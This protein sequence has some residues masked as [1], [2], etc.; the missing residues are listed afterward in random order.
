LNLAAPFCRF[1]S[2]KPQQLRYKLSTAYAHRSGAVNLL[3]RLLSPSPGRLGFKSMSSSGLGSPSLQ[4]RNRPTALRPP[5]PLGL[6]PVAVAPHVAH[7][8][9][10][11]VPGAP[12][13]RDLV[14]S[15]AARPR[16]ARLTTR[17][18]TTVTTAHRRHHSPPQLAAAPLWRRFPGSQPPLSGSLPLSPLLTIFLSSSCGAKLHQAHHRLTM[19]KSIF[20]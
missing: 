7:A 3:T 14:L 4:H 11:T 9:R 1:R 18:L 5:A 17:P 15:R 8:S 19:V 6:P 12:H 20:D 10:P 13:H 2:V 16:W